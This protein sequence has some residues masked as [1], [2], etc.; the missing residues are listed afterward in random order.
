MDVGSSSSVRRVLGVNHPGISRF[1]VDSYP[2]LTQFS[3]Q[4]PRLLFLRGGRRPRRVR[5]H[6]ETLV[7]EELKNGN[8]YSVTLNLTPAS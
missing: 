6:V 1:D 8:R 5:E 4:I 3:P 2:V 7:T